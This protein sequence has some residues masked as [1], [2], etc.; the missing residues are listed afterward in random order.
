MSRR[1]LRAIP[2]EGPDI[3]DPWMA[4]GLVA[5]WHEVV[6]EG[7]P[8]PER[9]AR[10]EHRPALRY[11]GRVNEEAS[12]SGGSARP[13]GEG[14]WVVADLPDTASWYPHAPSQGPGVSGD[15]VRGKRALQPRLAV[16]G[17]GDRDDDR[18]PRTLLDSPG[19]G[20]PAGA[21]EHGGH[22]ERDGRRPRRRGGRQPGPPAPR[23]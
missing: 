19:R 1:R 15:S 16:E 14:R 6:L 4:H 3:K 11:R 23:P 10:D 9:E 2:R 7:Q 18:A 22:S 5:A 17:P 20:R 21:E 8:A 12:G 13:G